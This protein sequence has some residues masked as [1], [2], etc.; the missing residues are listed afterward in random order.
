[1]AGGT[2]QYPD[3]FDTPTFPAGP[4]IASARALGIGVMVVFFLVI[5]SCGLL[6]WVQRSARVH[7]FL[8]SVNVCKTLLTFKQFLIL[9]GLKSERRSK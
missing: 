5:V 9:I 2:L 3:D 8:V 4:Y 7:P 1:M 6:L